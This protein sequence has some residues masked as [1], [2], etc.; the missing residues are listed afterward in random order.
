L[1]AP[2]CLAG[3]VRRGR[4][5]T[6]SLPLR[7]DEPAPFGWNVR[8]VGEGARVRPLGHGHIWSGSERQVHILDGRRGVQALYD[9]I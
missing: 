5:S 1:H 6:R 8:V 3:T 7:C 9:C 4:Q 2:R